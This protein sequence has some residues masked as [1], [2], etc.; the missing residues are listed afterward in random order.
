MDDRHPVLGRG[1]GRELGVELDVGLR[2]VVDQLD[3]PP[4]QA[5]RGVDL[6][7]RELEAG[8]HRLAVDV[9]PARGVVDAG[10][11]DR[12]GAERGMTHDGRG[13]K[14]RAGGEQDAFEGVAAAE[15]HLTVSLWVYVVSL[16]GTEPI[17]AQQ[18]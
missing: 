14:R 4:E 16:P 3:R 1:L 18:T 5:A 12:I 11:L 7:H 9:E 2:I 15:G 17:A 13:S 6:V 10:D 8:D